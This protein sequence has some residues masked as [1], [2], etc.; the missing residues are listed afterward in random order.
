MHVTVGETGKYLQTRSV[1]VHQ[2]DF[3]STSVDS[4]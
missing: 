4:C 2:K 3:T 1:N